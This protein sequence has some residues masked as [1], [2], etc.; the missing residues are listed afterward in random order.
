MTTGDESLVIAVVEL[1]ADTPAATRHGPNAKPGEIVGISTQTC[2]PSTRLTMPMYR[3]FVCKG[4]EDVFDGDVYWF[5][6]AYQIGTLGK[7]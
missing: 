1:Y 4:T 5:A 6:M 7:Y 2:L 3:L